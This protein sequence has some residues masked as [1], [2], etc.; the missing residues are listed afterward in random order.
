MISLANEDGPS[1][2][3]IYQKLI[4]LYPENYEAN[5]Q[6]ALAYLVHAPDADAIKSAVATLD[7]AVKLRP[8]SG[9]AQL[10]HGH[11]S[12]YVET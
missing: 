3:Q 2:I 6:L 1:A 8:S 10:P 4:S 7:R 11:L 9:P 5:Y 12:N